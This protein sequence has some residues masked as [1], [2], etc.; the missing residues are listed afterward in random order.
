MVSASL[1]FGSAVF[2]LVAMTVQTSRRMVGTAVRSS[3]GLSLNP[4]P[5][6]Y[7]TVVD[8]DSYVEFWLLEEVILRASWNR[9]PRAPVQADES[10]SQQR[11]P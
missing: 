3:S 8:D 2:L 10:D 1:H 11:L 7:T 9:C 4:Y 6:F 5:V